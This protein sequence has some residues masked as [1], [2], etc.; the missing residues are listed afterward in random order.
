[1]RRIIAI[2]FSLALLLSLSLPAFAADTS[3]DSQRL[4]NEREASEQYQRLRLCLD[5]QKKANLSRNVI[6]DYYGGA[7]IND[8][9]M[10]VICVTNDYDV[11]SKALETYTGSDTVITQRV[12]YTYDYLR[13]E[14]KKIGATYEALKNST[15]KLSEQQLIAARALRGVSVDESENILIIELTDME[16]ETIAAFCNTFTVP[17]CAE[18]RQKVTVPA[19]NTA[20]ES[21][22]A[23]SGEETASTASVNSNL[24]K[25]GSTI[26]ADGGELSVGYPVYFT[27][28]GGMEKRGFITIGHHFDVGD[29]VS[30]ENGAVVA[31]CYRKLVNTVQVGSTNYSND[32]ALFVITNN[33]YSMSNVTE[34]G[35]V[36]LNVNTLSYTRPAQGTTVYLEGYAEDGVYGHVR[37]GE[38]YDSYK[39]IYNWECSMT[40]YN[41][42]HVS[43]YAGDGDGGGVVYTAPNSN[44]VANIVGTVIYLDD[45]MYIQTEIYVYFVGEAVN[46][47]NCSLWSELEE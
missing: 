41:M 13:A 9:G 14:Q 22:S 19:I 34:Y 6:I 32:G 10:L 31:Q 23:G 44:N 33:N 39:D 28:T 45:P 27:V 11:S 43:G 30:L 47:L 38:I 35:R 42:I 8:D 7:Y 40:M 37:P 24:I 29:T 36:S 4:T 15:K 21:V 17:V 2:A 12:D 16:K 3:V 20:D 1:M 26:V 5:E 46:N 25:P 18:F